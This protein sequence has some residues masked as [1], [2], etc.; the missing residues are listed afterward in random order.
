MKR[1]Y[2]LDSLRIVAICAVILLHVAGSYWYKLDV[3]SY[4]WQVMNIYDCITR[5]GVPVFVMISGALFLDPNRPHTIRK[6]WMKNIPRIVALILFWGALYALLYE[7]PVEFTQESILQLVKDAIFGPGHLW[8][9]FMLLGLYILVPVLRCIT[10]NK[11]AAQYFLVIGLVVNFL[12]P[13]L[14]VSGAAPAVNELF[15]MLLIQLPIG[16]SFYFVL[17]YYLMA[18]PLKRSW[19][20]VIYI[21]GLAGLAASILATSFSS[22]A[23]GSADNTFISGSYFFMFAAASVFIFAQQLFEKHSPSDEALHYV[24]AFS[25]C[26]LGVYV[27]HIIVLRTLISIGLNATD[28]DPV[29]AVP[30]LAIICAGLSFGI[31]WLLKKIPFFGRYL[32]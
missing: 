25:D 9:L 7:L 3:V 17:G 31:A 1:L 2:F 16:Y 11:T 19:R 29:F 28:F 22:L 10:Q 12:F 20:I 23:Q 24:K 4:S 26:T 32:V 21:I 8:F 6:M 14:S 27:V 13:L 30:L 15:D 18:Y 5:W